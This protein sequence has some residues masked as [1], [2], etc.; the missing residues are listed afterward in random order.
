M[1]R[2]R[3]VEMTTVEIAKKITEVEQQIDKFT[4]DVKKLRRQK[5]ELKKDLMVAE[6][7]EAAAEEEEIMKS[8]VAMIKKKGLTMEQ[9][10]N[11][12][13][14]SEDKEIEKATK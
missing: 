9:V 10:K 4:D 13:S 2:T 3:K 12:L 6:K 7:K 1:A 5:K 14:N 11:I 8:L